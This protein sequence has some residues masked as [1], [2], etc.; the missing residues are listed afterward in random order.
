MHRMT[1]E[2]TD[3]RNDLLECL[4]YQRDSVLSIVNGLSEA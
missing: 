2:L 1:D 4:Q 3:E